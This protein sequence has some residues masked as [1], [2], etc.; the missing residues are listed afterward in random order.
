MK[1]QRAI[2]IVLLLAVLIGFLVIVARTLQI[3]SWHL[4]QWS[5]Q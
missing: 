4:P 5:R 3:A 2:D 1:R